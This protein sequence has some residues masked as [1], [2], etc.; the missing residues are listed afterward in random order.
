MDRKQQQKYDTGSPLAWLAR[1]LIGQVMAAMALAL[2]GVL[3]ALRSGLV[4]PA[5]TPR[6]QPA[7]IQYSRRRRIRRG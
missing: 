2:W 1:A 6:L 4:P 5:P 7:P 3:V